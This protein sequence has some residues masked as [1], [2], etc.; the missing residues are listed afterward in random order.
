MTELWK[1][2]GDM[3]LGPGGMRRALCTRKGMGNIN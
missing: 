3:K 2:K 1:W